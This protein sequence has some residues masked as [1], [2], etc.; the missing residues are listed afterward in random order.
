MKTRHIIITGLLFLFTFT[1]FAKEGN[2]EFEV[3]DTEEKIF[4]SKDKDYLQQWHYEQILK[5]D[6]SEKERDNYFAVLN[7]YTYKMSK[8]G[9]PK[10][11]YTDAERNQKFDA[12]AEKLKVEMKENLSPENFQIHYESFGKIKELVY[13]K[14]HW[15]E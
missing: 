12:L 7:N 13:E 14:R 4:T 10:F 8:L 15:E 6:I 1:T 5:M 2:M 9:S 11:D 3:N